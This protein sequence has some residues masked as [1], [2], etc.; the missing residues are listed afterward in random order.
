M[1][2]KGLMRFLIAAAVSATA[3]FGSMSVSAAET[4]NGIRCNQYRPGSCM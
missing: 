1:S 2:R 3:L 4:S